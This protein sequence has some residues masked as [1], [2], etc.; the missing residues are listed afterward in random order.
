MLCPDIYLPKFTEILA[1]YSR[2]GNPRFVP[3]SFAGEQGAANAFYTIG[4][5]GGMGYSPFGID[6]IARSAAGPNPPQPGAASP[7]GSR[8]AS[9]FGSL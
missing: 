1:K 6:S 9:A 3:E 7:A 5:F 8:G 2:S 4:M